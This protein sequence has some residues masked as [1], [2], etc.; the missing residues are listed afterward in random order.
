MAA[1]AQLNQ[2]LRNNG[3]IG[4]SSPITA[5][6]IARHFWISDGGVKVENE[7]CYQRSNCSK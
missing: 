2:Y 6:D 5:E 7:R 3:H 4:S 1:V